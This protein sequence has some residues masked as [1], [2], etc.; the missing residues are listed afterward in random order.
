MYNIT[1]NTDSFTPPVQEPEEYDP[2]DLLWLAVGKFGWSDEEFATNFGW[3]LGTI[4][5]WTC[6]QKAGRSARIRA[7]T[8]KREWGL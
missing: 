7:A 2:V 3:Q 1:Q 6:G 5:K 8:L 4:R